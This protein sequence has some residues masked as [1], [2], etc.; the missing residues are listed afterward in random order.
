MPYLFKPIEIDGEYYWDGGYMGNPPLDPLIK[1]TPHTN[2]ILIVQVN[3]FNIKKL[4]STIEEIKDRINE[5]SL[6]PH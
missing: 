4:P 5:I 6:T 1:N 3:P 2:D